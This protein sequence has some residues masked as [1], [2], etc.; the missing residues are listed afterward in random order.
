MSINNPGGFR[1]DAQVQEVMDGIAKMIDDREGATPSF[2]ITLTSVE[3]G[4]L[5]KACTEYANKLAAVDRDDT[6]KSV[7][8][9]VELVVL[10]RIGTKFAKATKQTRDLP[11]SEGGEV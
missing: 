8:S 1:D 7:Q 5:H 4:V 11:D 10:Q 9:A 3:S 6:G 2:T